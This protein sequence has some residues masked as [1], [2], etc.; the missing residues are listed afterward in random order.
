MYTEKVRYLDQHNSYG[1]TTDTNSDSNNIIFANTFHIGNSTSHIFPFELIH[2]VL[3]EDHN[4][5]GEDFIRDF[6]CDAQNFMEMRLS[7]QDLFRNSP[8]NVSKIGV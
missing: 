1:N 7:H 6:V 2:R 5:R 4:L 8:Q 3:Y